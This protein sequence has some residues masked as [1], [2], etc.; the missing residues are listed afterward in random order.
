MRRQISIASNILP[1]KPSLPVVESMLLRDGCL[2]ATDL[3]MSISLPVDSDLDVL[4]PRKTAEIYKALD[5]DVRMTQPDSNRVVVT[6]DTG[7][8]VLHVD[9]DIESFPVFNIDSEMHDI[10]A[11]KF[12]EALKSVIFAVSGDASRPAFNG[13]YIEAGQG[14]TLMASDTYRVAV[15]HIKDAI[16]PEYKVL[17]PVR[18]LRELIKINPDNLNIGISD[19]YIT[20]MSTDMTLSSRLLAEKYPDVRSVLPKENKT[21][22]GATQLGLSSPLHDMLQRAMLVNDRRV[23]LS[24]SD[25][26]LTVT[27]QSQL[28]VMEETLQVKQSGEDV[29]LDIDPRYLLDITRYDG[30]SISFNGNRGPIVVLRPGY[31]YW[32]LML[33][34]GGTDD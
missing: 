14:M 20:F 9:P 31:K 30:L 18:V 21:T 34:K 2:T 33:P 3:E 1:K 16:T 4:L 15:A 26:N 11:V 29:T 10:D 23:T 13:V 32:Y 24:V 25:N 27:A 17:V 22:I 7:K 8:F 28:S 6:S 5:G 12:I 19:S